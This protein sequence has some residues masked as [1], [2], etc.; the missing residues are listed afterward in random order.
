MPKLVRP[1]L[2]CNESD[3]EA[4]ELRRIALRSDLDS[5]QYRNGG[6]I[7]TSAF[8]WNDRDKDNFRFAQKTETRREVT[9]HANAA[10]NDER[11]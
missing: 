6:K 7:E 8:L 11:S 3:T 1:A 5:K 10:R 4:G 9:L 2:K